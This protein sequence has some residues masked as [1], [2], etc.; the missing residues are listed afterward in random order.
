[1]VLDPDSE[2]QAVTGCGKEE[3]DKKGSHFT[4][5][6]KAFVGNMNEDLAGG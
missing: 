3:F 6:A 1:M 4:R 2:Q 5:A